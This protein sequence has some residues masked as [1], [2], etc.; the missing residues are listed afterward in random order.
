MQPF[1]TNPTKRVNDLFLEF[2][3]VL[4]L[5]VGAVVE[6]GASFKDVEQATLTL[7][8]E[9]GRRYL[10]KALQQKADSYAE[11]LWINHHHDKY[12][13]HS[14]NDC[15]YRHHQQGTVSYHSLLGD[16]TVCRSTYRYSEVRNGPTVV[17]LE[18][19]MGLIERC[20]PA[21]ARSVALGYAKGP[22]RS[23]REDLEAAHRRPPSR[24]ALEK[25]AKKMGMNAEHELFFIEPALRSE[26]KVPKQAVFISLGSDRT[27]V[28][29]EEP[30][31]EP[32]QRRLRRK[33][34]R[35]RKKPKPI[36]V[37]WRMD[38]VG[39][40]CFLDKDGEPLVTRRYRLA[41]YRDIGLLADRMCADVEHALRN[42]PKLKVVVAQD[43]APELWNNV[44]EHLRRIEIL[45]EWYEVLD[46][47]HMT[48][49]LGHC[50]QL[51][52][53]DDEKR[54]ALQ[55]R[56]YRQLERITGA[57]DGLLHWLRRQRLGLSEE[58]RE[59]LNGHI[60]YFTKR[61]SLM[62]Y[63][64]MRRLNLPIGSGTTEGACKSLIGA[65]AKRSGQ[66]WRPP[67][68]GAVLNLRAL[69]QSERLDHFWRHFELRYRASRIEAAA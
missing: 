52:E 25:I 50:L 18:L 3:R 24:A 54:E 40:V 41:G 20:T 59:E 15:R 62:E 58:Q 33:K 26:E 60:K 21:L 2:D 65:R 10:E 51:I 56:W 22:I 1:L 30:R 17:P 14:R 48:E 29:M 8:N 7:T 5:L 6:D 39:T 55:D 45:S 69:H 38:Y 16:L 11:E 13:R 44:R 32:R 61:R 37:K 43:G 9:G 64:K 53:S 27:A 46:W 28:P 49:R 12:G 67:G 35:V 31:T 4:G 34:P 66:R 68:L 36:E 23:Y 47:Y 57:A 63:A 42:R 19:E